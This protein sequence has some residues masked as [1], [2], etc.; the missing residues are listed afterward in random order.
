LEV[1]SINLL[2]EHRSLVQKGVD[3]SQRVFGNLL[4]EFVQAKQDAVP[5]LMTAER[6]N[7]RLNNYSE[8]ATWG[9]HPHFPLC[10]FLTLKILALKM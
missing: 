7:E 1:E 9:G 2:Y 6:E 5:Q 10:N 3:V 8:T 4:G